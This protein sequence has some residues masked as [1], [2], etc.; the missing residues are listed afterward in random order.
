MNETYELGDNMSSKTSLVGEW[1]GTLQ[2]DTE[3]NREE[4]FVPKEGFADPIQGYGQP[5][6]AAA[7]LQ[8]RHA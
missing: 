4:T 3:Q 1:A 7:F 5:E 2:G 6:T 8:T